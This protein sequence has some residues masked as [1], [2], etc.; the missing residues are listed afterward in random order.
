MFNLFGAS[1]NQFLAKPLIVIGLILIVIGLSTVI[2]SKRITRVARQSNKVSN[3]DGLYVFLKI[4]G[5]LLIL[6]GFVCISIDI[7]TYIVNKK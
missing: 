2:L 5:L 7:V 3:S 1:L 6:A 4:L